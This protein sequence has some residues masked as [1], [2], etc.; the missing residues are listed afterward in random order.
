MFGSDTSQGLDGLE[1]LWPLLPVIH[2]RLRLGLLGEDFSHLIHLLFA[3]FDIVDADVGDERNAG[4]HG[5][6]SS[7]LAVF[8]GDAL[9]WLDA[10]L[11]AGVEVD[12]WIWLGGWWVERGGS[13]VDVLILEEACA[14]VSQCLGCS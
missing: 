8:D 4:T 5:S 10:E 1:A 3:F 11:L 14:A 6:S 2:D 9:L 12:R 13:G 7:G